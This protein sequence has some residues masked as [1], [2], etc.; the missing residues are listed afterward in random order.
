MAGTWKTQNKR[1]PGAYI[2]VKG[3]G[4]P[5]S[6][7][8]VGR[9]LML[10]DLTLN[11]GKTGVVELSAT[12][13]F[14]AEL[15]TK[16]DDPQLLPLKQAL[17]GAETV[18][19][20]NLNNGEKATGTAETSPLKFKAKY[21]GT[22]GNNIK[23]VIEP[24]AVESGQTP[25]KATVSTIFDAVIVDQQTI[26][27]DALDEY[28]ENDYVVPE[29]NSAVTSLPTSPVTINLTG[30]TTKADDLTE[31]FN[32]A[33]DSESYSVVT[34][35]GMSVDS[36]MHG[37]LVEALK[38]LR[39]NEGVKVRGIIPANDN[40][41][42]YNYEGVSMVANGFIEGDGTMVDTT[43]AA[44][45]FAGVSASATASEAL[46]YHNVS[47]AV[48][49]WP[50]LNNEETIDALNAGKI[51]FTTRAGQRVVVEQ[52]IN[53]LIKFTAERTRDFSKNR[54]IRTLD[55]ICTNTQET[56]E[57]SYLGRVPNNENGRALFK[58]NRISYLT[59]LQAQNI[60]QNWDNGDI[61]VNA[62]ND[63]DAIVVDVAVTPVDAME[64]LYMTLIVN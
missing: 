35:A 45:Y 15:G 26:T 8:P 12:S 7:S 63:K 64:K 31:V 32:T 39:E 20:L 14:R 44:A 4:N 58:A 56:F 40:T 61:T 11:W 6:P 49:A 1:R 54:I 28:L 17:K 34:T 53:S 38:R 30:G 10:S 62:G 33:L 19:F 29:I 18:L 50:K 52:D 51:V 48:E 22:K 60:I 21:A 25:K 16:L 43:N 41:P 5:L 13:D 42:V 27:I 23:V 57:N 3:N 36:N 37:L 24:E 9:L 2:N 59:T 55:E 46:T 47:D